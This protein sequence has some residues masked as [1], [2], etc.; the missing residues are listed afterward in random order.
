MGLLYTKHFILTAALFDEF[1]K[2]Y[3]LLVHMPECSVRPIDDAKVWRTYVDECNYNTFLHSQGW[4]DFNRRY[5][6]SAFQFGLYTDDDQ[7]LS[8]A[9]VLKISAKR[10]TFL[11]IPHGPQFVPQSDTLVPIADQMR[12]W[13]DYL[14]QL[15]VEHQC[16]F[17][18]ISPILHNSP[19][20]T[21]VFQ[22]VGFRPAPI[23]MHAE[24]TTVVDLQPEEKQ[25][26]KNMRK[27]MRQMIKKGT[28]LLQSGEV[29]LQVVTQVDADMLAVYQSTAERGGFVPFSGDY[30]QKEYEAFAVYDAAVMCKICYQG[31][32]L[33][34]GM[35]VF[36]G[37]RAFYHQGANILN[38]QVPASYMSH[39]FGMQQAKQ[40]GCT[41]YD[42]WGVGPVNAPNHP[43]A[44]ISTFKRGFGGDDIKLVHAQDYPLRWK[45]WINWVIE[46][47][48]AKRRG[49]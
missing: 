47:I 5:G 34:W 41:T 25:I 16:D 33:S 35:W 40:H 18:R 28:K 21:A 7:I 2:T 23:H 13:T 31:K 17:I 9:M 29:E 43:W 48:R 10:A 49:F 15:G 30:L 19:D 38:K 14:Q 37:E 24:L 39:W 8:L 22:H 4:V 27:T 3:Y 20:N 46:F 26:L 1:T 6:H 44:N 42:F 36:S 32:L 11:F 45:Y 12:A